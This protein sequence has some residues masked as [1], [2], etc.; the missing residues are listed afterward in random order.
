MVG[1][2]IMDRDPFLMT[3]LALRPFPII[4]TIKRPTFP[5][6][7]GNLKVSINFLFDGLS[8]KSSTIFSVEATRPSRLTPVLKGYRVFL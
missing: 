6:S 1:L 8:L 7:S 2:W 3:A 5:V 4:S